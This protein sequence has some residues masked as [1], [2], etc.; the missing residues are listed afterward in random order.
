[1]GVIVAEY[2][3]SFSVKSFRPRD[4]EPPP[5]AGGGRNPEADFHG[6][7]RRNETDRSTTGP[8]ARLARKGR[9]RVVED[10]PALGVDPFIARDQTRH[11]RV[12]PPG[13]RGRIPK[14]LSPRDRMRR[15]LQTRRGGERYALRMETVEPVFGQIKQGRSFRQFLLRG[16]EKGQGEWSLTCSG[17]NLLELFRLDRRSAH[18][19]QPIPC[20]P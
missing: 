10:L 12:P 7:R 20:A 16:L 8:N 14:H 17:H 3:T 9:G 13:P 15:K 11:V 18:S 6:E 2:T 1:M 19:Q 5:P 4:E